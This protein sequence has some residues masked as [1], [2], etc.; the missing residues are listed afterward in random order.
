MARGAVSYLIREGLDVPRKISVTAFD[1][2]RVSEEEPPTLTA[3]DTSP[4]LMGRVAAEILLRNAE[5]SSQ[6]F[7]DI[8]LAADLT[9]RESSGPAFRRKH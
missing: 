5:A 7:V 8:V 1:R 3:A 6:R 9:C 2:T 4:E